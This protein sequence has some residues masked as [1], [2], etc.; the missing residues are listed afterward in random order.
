MACF[1]AVSTAQAQEKWTLRQCIDHAVENNIA[2]RQ[3]ALA[4]KSAETNLNTSRNSRLPDLTAGINQNFSFGRMASDIDNSYVNTQASSTSASLS[5]GLPVF[6]GFRINHEIKRGELELKAAAEGLE[7]AKQNLELNVAGYFLDVLFRREIL[8]VY[9]EQLKLSKQRLGQTEE[10][11]RTGKVAESQVLDMRSQIA[12]SEVNVTNAQNDLRMSL[13]NLS[14]AL[15][16]EWSPSFDIAIPDIDAAV[17]RNMSEIRQPNY[18]YQ[19]ALEIKPHIREAEYRLQG[20]EQQVMIAKSARW[21]SISLGASFG[22]SYY[23]MFGQPNESLADQLC[24]KHSE[25]I[26][27]NVSIPIFNRFST[28]NSIRLARINTANYAL[29]LENAKLDLYKEI[30]QAYQGAV[31]AQAKF[32]ASERAVEAAEESFRAMELRFEYG[33]ATAY[34][35]NE[36]QTKLISSRSDLL[37]AKYDFLFR[38]KILDFYEGTPIDLK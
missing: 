23:Y 32:S 11:V 3:Q 31:S 15:N 19:T 6:Q 12:A 33:K 1:A 13:L 9:E 7:K 35:Y 2:V 26:G 10:M 5:A 8:Y 34:E 36:S 38:S 14:Q 4:V 24:N 20:S 25:S 16:L 37:Q 17:S 30:Q 22:D 28:R 29:Q 21:P 27:I 18:V